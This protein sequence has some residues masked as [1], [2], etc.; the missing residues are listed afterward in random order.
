MF[1]PVLIHDPLVVPSPSPT[2]IRSIFYYY[3]SP[4]TFSQK[5]NTILIINLS[6]EPLKFMAVLGFVISQK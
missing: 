3:P 1:F 4:Y 5:E 2:V 6:T